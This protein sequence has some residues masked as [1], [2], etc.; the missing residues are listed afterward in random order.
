MAQISNENLNLIKL[1]NTNKIKVCEF[2]SSPTKEGVVERNLSK[3][4]LPEATVATRKEWNL[5]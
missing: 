5:K 3:V 1:K 4:Q 2:R